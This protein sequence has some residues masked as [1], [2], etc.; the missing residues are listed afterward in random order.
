[1][2]AP[3]INRLIIH[4][5][6]AFIVRGILPCTVRRVLRVLEVLAVLVLG[7]LEVLKVR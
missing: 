6:T 2:I 5:R 1:M 7:V 3:S 4:Q